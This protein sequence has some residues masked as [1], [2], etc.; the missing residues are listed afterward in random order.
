MHRFLA[1]LVEKVKQ[2]TGCLADCRPGRPRR[3]V[4]PG[5]EALEERCLL[6]FALTSTSWTPVGPAPA[7]TPPSGLGYSGEGFAAG[8]IDVAAPDPRDPN[9]MYIGVPGGGVWKTSN[10]LDTID[11]PTWTPLTDDQPS[12]AFGGY[13]S[14]LIHPADHN[15]IYGAVSGVGGGILKSSKNGAGWQ[16][17]ANAQFE[18]ASLGS[19]VGHP[20]DPNTLYLAAWG[21]GTDGGGIYKSSDGG[22]TWQ[23]KTAAPGALLS[24]N[25]HDGAAS[26]VVIDPTNPNVLYAGLVAL[27]GGKPAAPGLFTAGIYKSTDGGEHWTRLSNGLPSGWS[28]GSTIRLAL[29]PSAPNTVYATVFE[30]TLDGD[31]NPYGTGTPH[32]YRTT[33]G[34]QS[35]T[36]LA[37][38]PGDPEYRSWHVLLAVDPNDANH[39]FVNDSYSLW[40]SYTGGDAW[41]RADAFFYYGK[42]LT[43]GDDWVNM[44]FDAAGHGVVTADRNIYL[45]DETSL[46]SPLAEWWSQQGNLQI[47]QFWDLTLDPTNAD[48]IF[49]IAQDHYRSLGGNGKL[50]WQYT[51]GG[52]ELGKILIDPQNPKLLYEYNPQHSDQFVLRSTDGGD[53]WS[54]ILSVGTS[55]DTVAKYIQRSFVMDPSNP[56]RLLV[57][58]TQVLETVDPAAKAWSVISPSVWPSGSKPGPYVSALA[59]APSDGKTVYAAT[60]DGRVAVTSD[61][62]TKWQAIDNAL[63]SNKAG[64]V[65]DI[66]I[67]PNNPKR[68]FAV[69]NGPGGKNVWYLPGLEKANDWLNVS[70]DLPTNLGVHTIFVDWQYAI[71]ALYVGTDRGVYHSVNQGANW[72]KFASGLPNTA[73][74]DLQFLPQQNILAAATGGRG[75]WEILIPPSQVSGQVYWDHN[76]NGAKDA[77]DGGLGGWTVY[78]DSNGNGKLDAKEYST[79]TNAQGQYSFA[80]VPPGTYSIREVVPWLWL[81]TTSP[82]DNVSL[83]GSSLTQQD[84]GNAK[85]LIPHILSQLQAILQQAPKQSA[86]DQEFVMMGSLT[87]PVTEALSLT[88]DYGD[89]T[90]SQPLSLNADGSFALRH[91]YT[92]GCGHTL[93]IGVVDREG[94]TGFATLAVTVTENEAPPASPDPLPGPLTPPRRR[95]RNRGRK[96]GGPLPPR[97]HHSPAAHP[98]PHHGRAHGRHR[99]R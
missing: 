46:S 66:R 49:G 81:Q 68:A 76:S 34:G 43:V 99:R 93:T 2:F 40:E 22:W 51:G 89:G 97:P 11:G 92:Q 35:W 39:V 64:T 65:T 77:G 26:D 4:R 45:Q 73:V 30:T 54:P 50:L 56:Q 36:P 94:E 7:E 58:T 72:M 37:S 17:L 15:S 79:T 60:S 90:G 86:R 23:N 53:S 1:T 33:D 69:T 57:G 59:I 87:W 25:K 19:L 16:V 9:V 91:T 95:R 31:P 5:I 41:H 75:A 24:L 74:A 32:R 27:A 63:V 8:R 44:T 78:L 47:T 6:S 14:L 18:G 3:R 84:F 67:D 42:K 62:G 98:H 10:W 29:A 70:G 12:L 96:P 61:G 13:N 88:V 83:S 21:G 85:V 52:D 71:S 55:Y 80:A 20:Q 38:T 82:H 48:R 28:V